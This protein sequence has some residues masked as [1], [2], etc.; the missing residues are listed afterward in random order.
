MWKHVYECSSP[1][2]FRTFRMLIH[3]LASEG[4]LVTNTLVVEK[5]HDRVVEG[6]SDVYADEDGI[7]CM[8][9]HCR[10]SRRRDKSGQW[11]F[12]PAHF[13]IHP[14]QVSHGLCQVCRA[15]FYPSK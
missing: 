1:D 12:V 5:P 10:C 6:N 2:Q 11:D 7:I 9:A 15:Y 8:C 3:L 4:L 13:K 14:L